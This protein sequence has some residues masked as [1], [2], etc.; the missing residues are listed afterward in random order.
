M[1]NIFLSKDKVK[2]KSLIKKIIDSRKLQCKINN[3]FLRGKVSDVRSEEQTEELMNLVYKQIKQFVYKYQPRYYRQYQGE[4][5]DLVSDIFTDF[6]RP[7]K[8]RNGE[9]FSELDRVDTE[10]VGNGQW[11]GS[12]EKALATYTQ[13]FV[14]HSLI[15]YSR[16]DKGEVHASENYNENEGKPTLDRLKNGRGNR[17]IDGEDVGGAYQEDINYKFYDLMDNPQSLK[18]AKKMLISNPEQI[19]YILYL[20]KHYAD[21][22]EPDVKKFIV[23]MIEAVYLKVPQDPALDRK[24]KAAAKVMPD[25]LK[26]HLES[27]LPEESESSKTDIGTDLSSVV[28]E[29]SNVTKQMLRGKPALRI[30]PPAD[31]FANADTFA[32]TKEALEKLGY[33]YYRSYKGNWYFFSN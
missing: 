18:N 22:L 33:T 29:G 6:C 1:A 19:G 21:K 11:T 3:K 16:S 28:P 26:E 4:L 5:G 24:L 9:V 10:K 23:N 25:D 13:R 30:T 12:K 15:D 17:N 8:H 32:T 20:L 14:M 31:T 7:K 27:L 2:V